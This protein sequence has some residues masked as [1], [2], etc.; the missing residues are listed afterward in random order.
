MLELVSFLLLSLFSSDQEQL[1]LTKMRPCPPGL[2]RGTWRGGLPVSPPGGGPTD[3][4]KGCSA[5]VEV[6]LAEDE[7]EMMDGLEIKLEELAGMMFE[8]AV[9]NGLDISTAV[10]NR[11]CPV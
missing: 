9:G 6:K 10:R 8:P 1:R 7:F 3:C 11:T 5:A 2:M 4:P